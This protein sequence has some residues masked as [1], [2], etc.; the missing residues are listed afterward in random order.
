MLEK[1]LILAAKAHTGQVDK[2]GAPYILHPIRVMLACEGEKEK[3]VALLHDTLEDTALTAADLRRAG[4]S[5][6]IVQA[7]CCLT[8]GQKEDYM[9][10]IAR[11]CE[12]ALAARVKYA[13]LQ[14]NLDISRIPNPTEKD[15]ARIR[16]YEQAMKKNYE[17]NQGRTGAWSIGHRNAMTRSAGN[18]M[19]SRRKPIGSFI[20]SCSAQICP[21]SVC[22]R[23]FCGK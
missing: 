7:V 21:S 18:C 2:G 11:I 23:P 6:E 15:F 12:N 5:E 13:D 10:Y 3:I 14:D 20:Q 22:A 1:A 16:K 8:R 17:I 4:F 9:D 19:H